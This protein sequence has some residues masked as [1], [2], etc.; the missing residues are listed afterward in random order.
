MDMQAASFVVEAIG[1]VIAFA[2]FVYT[3]KKDQKK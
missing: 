2:A 1:L 3:I